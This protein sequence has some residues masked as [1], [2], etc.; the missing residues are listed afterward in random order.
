[1]PAFAQTAGGFLT[2]ERS[3]WLRAE[4]FRIPNSRRNKSTFIRCKNDGKE[5]PLMARWFRNIL[6]ILPRV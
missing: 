2:D 1:M 4:S 3:T 6:R 5:M